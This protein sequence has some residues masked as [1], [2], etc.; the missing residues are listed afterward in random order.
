ML[1]LCAIVAGLLLVV[2]LADAW[3]LPSL[4]GYLPTQGAHAAE[5]LQ[6]WRPCRFL[7]REAPCYK[8]SVHACT[9]TAA[10]TC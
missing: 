6:A 3:T 5:P 9:S 7:D 4:V 1:P 10:H 8:V 2:Q